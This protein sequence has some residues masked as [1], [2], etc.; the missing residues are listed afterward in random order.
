MK[1]AV[2]YRF[3]LYNYTTGRLMINMEDIKGGDTASAPIS[4][5]ADRVQ[6][7]V[8]WKNY[9]DEPTE[10]W[11]RWIYREKLYGQPWSGWGDKRNPFTITLD[12]GVDVELTLDDY[13]P[14]KYGPTG[15]PAW[16]YY[17]M[18]IELYKVED[19]VRTMTDKL[20]IFID[21]DALTITVTCERPYPPPPTAP[22]YKI[23]RLDYPSSAKVGETV[24]ISWM[25][26]NLGLW[27]WGWFRLIDLDTGE[28]LNRGTFA[29]PAC[30]GVGDTWRFTMPD[31]DWR[32]RAEAGYD[33][34]VTD[35]REFTIA[36]PAPPAPM[37]LSWTIPASIFLGA[38]TL[39]LGEAIR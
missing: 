10:T 23:E 34:A 9:W 15:A 5:N 1:Y 20:R 25:V 14:M 6:W 11:L 8:W 4:G 24:E 35:S 27:G 39:V 21:N 3:Q 30:G 2:F 26:H 13:L 37:P 29:A 12:P 18:V 31:R 28:E 32:L 19:G 17:E 16:Q 22:D 36:L 38:V 33:N 7:R